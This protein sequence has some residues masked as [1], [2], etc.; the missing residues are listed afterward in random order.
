MCTFKWVVV[1][2]AVL[3]TI[4]PVGGPG[5]VFAQ[6][7]DGD[8]IH[9]CVD[10]KG[11]IRI[12]GPDEVCK[13]RETPLDWSIVGPQGPP[14]LDGLDGL[15]GPEGQQGLPGLDGLPGPVGPEGPLGSPGP[16]GP[17]GDSH[18]LRTGADTFYDAGNVGIGVEPETALDVNGVTRTTTLEIS[19]GSP[20]EQPLVAW[21]E[22][23]QDQMPTTGTFTAISTGRGHMAIRSDGTLVSWGDDGRRNVSTNRWAVGLRR[24]HPSRLTSRCL[25]CA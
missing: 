4:G 3:L 13:A 19:G 11:K 5:R 1:A 9:A 23:N 15:P 22:V 25:I 21:G 8:V 16:A 6:A 10:N 2:G 12:V 17:P 20:G 18:W 7:G 14:G 24:H